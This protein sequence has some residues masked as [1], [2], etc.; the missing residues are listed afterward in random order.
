[1]VTVFLPRRGIAPKG[2]DK[3]AQ[4]QSR[5]ELALSLLNGRDATLGSRR[6]QKPISLPCRGY[7][8]SAIVTT[9][10]TP[11]FLLLEVFVCRMNQKSAGIFGIYLPVAPPSMA[12]FQIDDLFFGTSPGQVHREVYGPVLAFR[13][14][15]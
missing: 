10:Q 14:C 6:Q 3:S 2:L 8:S 5:V 1:M 11:S 12:A 15:S 9:V 7:I 4:G 13:S